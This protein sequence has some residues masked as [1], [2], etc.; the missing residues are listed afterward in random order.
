MIIKHHLYST[1]TRLAAFVVRRTRRLIY[2]QLCAVWTTASVMLDISKWQMIVCLLI[3]QPLLYTCALTIT[4]TQRV[5]T[6]PSRP[7][8]RRIPQGKPTTTTTMMMTRRNNNNNKQRESMK[9]CHHRRP[10][11]SPPTTNND[12]NIKTTTCNS[13]ETWKP[14][15]TTRKCMALKTFSRV[16]NTRLMAT[17]S[18]TILARYWQN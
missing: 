3:L 18:T 9:H 10:C 4:S 11:P 7:R 5:T 14:T 12:N 16:E 1:R 2:Y 6:R 13:N 17:S 15:C 8:M